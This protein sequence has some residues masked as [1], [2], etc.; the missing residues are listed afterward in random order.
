[1]LVVLES[2]GVTHEGARLQFLDSTLSAHA[3][4][5]R[6]WIQADLTGGQ[7]HAACGAR[8]QLPEP[9]SVQN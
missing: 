4:C 9:S 6:K 1:M 3:G 7:S 2:S 5:A 8:V